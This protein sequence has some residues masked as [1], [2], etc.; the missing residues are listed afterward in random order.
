VS[1]PAQEAFEALLGLQLRPQRIRQAAALWQEAGARFGAETRDG[2][3]EHP[4][5]LPSA[6]DLDDPADFLD[7]HAPVEI[8]D[9][10]SDL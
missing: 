7:R 10:L 1:G 9:D 4:G 3:W 8:P 6:A 2:W 5:L